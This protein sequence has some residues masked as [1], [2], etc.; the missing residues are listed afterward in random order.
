MYSIDATTVTKGFQQY[1]GGLSGGYGRKSFIK[2][3][4]P[5][6]G[7]WVRAHACGRR[8]HGSRGAELRAWSPMSDP[9]ASCASSGFALV[10]ATPDFP[11]AP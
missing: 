6:S 11:P 3:G 5:G 8:H 1:E 2:G 10:S 9:M 7:C 4:A